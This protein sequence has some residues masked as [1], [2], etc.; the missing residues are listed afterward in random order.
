MTVHG[1]VLVVSSEHGRLETD[2]LRWVEQENRI[3]TGA[4]VRVSTERDVVTG[5]G[6]EADPNLEEWRILCDVEGRFDRG[7]EL[8][9]QFGET[10]ER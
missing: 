3:T 10:Q 1:N 8:E 6:F 5:V 9:E 4:A 2:S 7:D